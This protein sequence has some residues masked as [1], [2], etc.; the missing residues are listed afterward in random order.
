MI[1]NWKDTVFGSDF[2]SD[3]LELVEKIEKQ[4]L[5]GYYKESNFLFNPKDDLG[6]DWT[7]ISSDLRIRNIP[8]TM[9][10]KVEGEKVLKPDNFI[11]GIPPGIDN[12]FQELFDTNE[13]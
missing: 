10:K 12:L 6:G 8:K 1:E 13:E 7:V 11:E 2:G 9:L 5:N 4:Y 3:F